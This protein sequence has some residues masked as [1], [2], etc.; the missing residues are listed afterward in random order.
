MIDINEHITQITRSLS[1]LVEAM[2][3][4]AAVD[5]NEVREGFESLEA[6]MNQKAA[7]DAAFAWLA[8]SFDAGRLVGATQTTEYLIEKLGLSRSEAISRLQQG[9]A[10]FDPVAE[11]ARVQPEPEE[12][13]EERDARTAEEKRRREAAEAAQKRAREATENASA[14]KRAMIEREL[15][16]LSEHASPGPHELR[17]QALKRSK[18]SGYSEL[19]QWLRQEI[20]R[21]NATAIKPDG[22]K[23][24]FAAHKK[25]HIT[26]TDQD[27]EGGVGFHGYL[28]AAQ[29]A[30]LKS[31]LSYNAITD[32][33]PEQKDNR[34][35]AQRRADKLF[36]IVTAHSAEKEVTRGG[37]GSVIISA[38]LDQLNECDLDTEFDTNT[39]VLLTP[40]DM[41]ALGEAACDY[42]VVHSD[43]GH[44]LNLG[45]GKRTANFAQRIALFA[46]E[47]CCSHPGCHRPIDECQAHHLI[48]W[49]LG[50]NTD[51]ENLTLLCFIH[52]RNNND[53]R[54]GKNN[55]GHA[56]RSPVNH[57]AGWRKARAPDIQFNESTVARRASAARIRTRHN[58][59]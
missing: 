52:H 25:R 22:K 36:A 50:G 6:A 40:L 10:L 4:P 39:G 34:S 59:Q 43:D 30:A 55:M 41:L 42:L 53:H 12:T 5:F 11:P 24:P 35:V 23:D 32:S 56:E 46:Q 18:I 29:A 7:I 15:K 47:L 9:K 13:K 2:R 37:I 48:A 44:L 21:A 3:E 20:K 38:T 1:G 19:R 33:N 28:P 27:S 8:H 26:F 57:R 54:D 14:A 49:L 51:I 17:E 58:V 45:R 31:A 16:N